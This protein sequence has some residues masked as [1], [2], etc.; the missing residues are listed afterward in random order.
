MRPLRR[1]GRKV[2]TKCGLLCIRAAVLVAGITGAPVRVVVPPWTMVMSVDRLLGSVVVM[3]MVVTVVVVM[4][5][6]VGWI[7]RIHRLKM[8]TADLTYFNP[9]SPA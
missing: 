1:D 2:R 5:R 8:S 9:E 6:S 3:V 4:V 7:I